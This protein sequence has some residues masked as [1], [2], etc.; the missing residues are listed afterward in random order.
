MR[1]KIKSNLVKSDLIISTAHG[2]NNKF[3]KFNV[4]PQ[5]QSCNSH[6]KYQNLILSQT[7]TPTTPL[8]RRRRPIPTTAC[9]PL[10]PLLSARGGN[11][12]SKL[13]S[14]VAGELSDTSVSCEET[15][16]NSQAIAFSPLEQ[17]VLKKPQVITV[18]LKVHMHCEACA[19]EIKRRIQRMKG[20]IINF[21]I[22]FFTLFLLFN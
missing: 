3:E 13:T 6:Q 14:D 17:Q 5:H 9:P 11:H 22:I 15:R 1:S 7:P 19:H 16:S 8:P 21:A 18:V 12:R 2:Q 10:P 20:K 4:L